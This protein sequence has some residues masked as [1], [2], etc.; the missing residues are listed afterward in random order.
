M[1]RVSLDLI[2]DV[3]WSVRRRGF[4]EKMYVVGHHFESDNFAVEFRRLRHDQGAKRGF[5]PSGQNFPAILRAPDEV[6]GQRR[7]AAAK[8]PV[9]LNA[10]LSIIHWR[11]IDGN[12]KQRTSRGEKYQATDAVA[13]LYLR[14]AEASGFPRKGIL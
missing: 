12:G 3:L 4:Q 11:S 14:M 10:H 13:A 6:V 7:N 5:H 2:R 9:S 8:V 1:G